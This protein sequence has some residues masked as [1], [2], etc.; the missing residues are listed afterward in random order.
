MP[1]AAAIYHCGIALVD[2]LAKHRH[3]VDIDAES[4]RRAV[5]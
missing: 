5:R 2:R 4:W 3:V 1:V